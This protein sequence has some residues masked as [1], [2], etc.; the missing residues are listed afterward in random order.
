MCRCVNERM[1]RK[2]ARAP[3]SVIVKRDISS[4]KYFAPAVTVLFIL[5]AG[6]G[7]LKHE[8][9]RDEYQAWM[10][11]AN[12]SSLA[13][14]YHNMR[15]D[16]HPMLWHTILFFLAKLGAPASSMKVVHLLIA[17]GSVWLITKYS[18][19]KWHEKIA[20]C[21]GYFTL[22]EYT[23]IS[24]SYALGLF[25]VL[26][27]CV[28]YRQRFK[29][30]IYLSICIFLMANTQPF[31]MLVGIGCLIFL[32]A[33]LLF[34]RNDLGV[35]QPLNVKTFSA[36]LIAVFGII[37]SYIQIS[38][39]SDGG[40]YATSE[41]TK[42]FNAESLSISVSRL[43]NAYFTIPKPGFVASW[44]S[45]IFFDH[46]PDSNFIIGLLIFC[47]SVFIFMHHQRA[48]FFY[49][50]GTCLLLLFFYLTSAGFIYSRYIGYLFVVLLASFW[51]S[52]MLPEKKILKISPVLADRSK[53]LSGIFMTIVL[54]AQLIGGA[55]AYEND[56]SNPFSNS[57]AAADYIKKSGLEKSTIVG[58][59]DFI[60]SSLSGA[61][62]KPIYYPEKKNFGTF[63]VWN[64]ERKKHSGFDEVIRSCSTFYEKEQKN[65]LLVLSN[66]L[67]EDKNGTVNIMQDIPFGDGYY[68][69][70]IQSFDQ[71]CICGDE[72]YYIYVFNKNEKN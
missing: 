6:L 43:I 37:I 12:S 61:L 21:F 53:K 63:I 71:S 4:E 44:N 65:I 38:P 35:E 17:A 59:W 10:L 50:S 52:R 64:R 47:I 22:Y 32:V 72:Q 13:D 45:T 36:F 39:P 60:A 41:F 57:G 11:A 28:L 9:W 29:N 8:F 48:L 62:N 16:G 30:I 14:C 19:F 3:E 23:I 49:L 15:Y 42:G 27:F 5:I 46:T 1:K 18:P 31:G 51:M 2:T 40:Y 54:C 20:A 24:R 66:P 56:W 25:F 67:N 26:L 70:L 7:M 68:A 34:S 58:A 55:I 69:H 33:E